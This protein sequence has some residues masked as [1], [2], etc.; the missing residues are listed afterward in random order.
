MA[1]LGHELRGLNRPQSCDWRV[2]KRQL[3]WQ[4][5]G[6]RT[7]WG[8]KWGEDNKEEPASWQLAETCFGCDRAQRSWLLCLLLI[9][10]FP[11]EAHLSTSMSIS[12]QTSLGFLLHNKSVTEHLWNRDSCCLQ[13]LSTELLACI[14]LFVPIPFL[15]KK[16]ALNHS[17]PNV[18]ELLL[19]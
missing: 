1:A 12:L 6:P 18:T 19:V 2:Q 17:H 7:Y 9:S 13:T 4:G 8:M 15:K 5:P 11:C 3:R 16:Q 10:L 14:N